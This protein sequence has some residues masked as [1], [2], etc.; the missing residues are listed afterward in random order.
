MGAPL[1]SFVD[2]Q[3]STGPAV[4]T[5]PDDLINDAVF[6]TYSFWRLLVGKPFK[7]IVTA[8]S[9][10]RDHLMLDVPNTFAHYS[11]N[12]VFKYASKN[13]LTR[14]SGPWRFSRDYMRWTD[15]EVGLNDPEGM[16]E[17]AIYQ[18]YVDF[19]DK[20]E[21]ELWTSMYNGLESSMWIP[22]DRLT[23]EAQ[24][25]NVP[26]SIP[27]GCNEGPNRLFNHLTYTDPI[28]GLAVAGTGQWTTHQTVDPTMPGKAKW[29]N[30]LAGYNSIIDPKAVNLAAATGAKGRSLNAALDDAYVRSGF[31]PPRTRHQKYFE[32]ASQAA[33]KVIFTSPKGITETFSLQRSANDRWAKF[34]KNDASMDMPSW[35]NVDIVQVDM[36]EIMPLYVNVAGTA[37]VSEGAATAAGR[38]PRF[39]CQNMKYQRV[40]IN[41]NRFF[42]R[43]PVLTPYD[44]P[45]SHVQVVDL[46]WNNIY[47][48]RMRTVLVTPG[49]VVGM[50]PSQVL[51][52][53]Q[54]YAAY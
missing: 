11:T 39:Y 45:F 43:T 41:R 35:G 44:Q 23:M 47:R 33:Q 31:Q 52:A 13:S 8:G 49:D 46:W 15:Q 1:V 26:Y 14:W 53:A 28:S 21:R 6:N 16:T 50:F 40:V 25:G 10:I 36:L 12:D 54:V 18:Q 29:K 30:M 48:S 37:L 4:L 51:T 42:E 24:D 34:P 27:A 7:E 3:E 20:L 2:F 32:P 38:G 5:P 17:D 9:E 19:Q 22:P